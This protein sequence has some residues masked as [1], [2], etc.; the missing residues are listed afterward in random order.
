MDGV[1]SA[2]SL[3]LSITLTIFMKSAVKIAGKC[4]NGNK[5]FSF[6]HTFSI[7]L[8]TS[9]DIISIELIMIPLTTKFECPVC[10][11]ETGKIVVLVNGWT[12]ECKCSVCK[13]HFTRT[14]DSH[15]PKYLH[16]QDSYEERLDREYNC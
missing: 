13:T 10:K 9:A 8:L 5:L 6:F 11:T 7:D 3:N 4:L 15:K 2:G 12:A 16:Y 1:R 14:V